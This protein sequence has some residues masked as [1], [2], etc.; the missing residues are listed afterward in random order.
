MSNNPLLKFDELPDF[1]LIKA[2]HIEQAVTNVLD[3]NKQVLAGLIADD[4][5]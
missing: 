4:E 3:Q 1:P 2:E 5:L